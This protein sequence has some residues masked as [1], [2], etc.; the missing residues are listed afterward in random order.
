MLSSRNVKGKSRTNHFQN[1]LAHNSQSKSR[2][3]SN[4]S[5]KKSQKSKKSKSK[6]KSPNTNNSKSRSRSAPRTC[7]NLNINL[8]KSKKSRSRSPDFHDISGRRKRGTRNKKCENLKSDFDYK[9]FMHGTIK[10][11]PSTTKLSSYVRNNRS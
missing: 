3:K 5:N 7:I 9:K 4:K 2:S 10:I 11:S 1:A 6:S 8:S